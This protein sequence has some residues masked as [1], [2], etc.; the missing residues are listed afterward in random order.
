MFSY[1]HQYAWVRWGNVR[2]EIF[3]INNGT[4]Q[5][6]IASPVFWAVY[7][8]LLIKE[9]RQLGVGAYIAGVF[10]GASAYADDLVL[11]APTRHAMQL[12]LGV[13]EN[14]A[15]CNNIL[16]STD[17]NPSLSK[18]K[19]IFMVGKNINLVKPAPL[20]L[21]GRE[22]PWVETA[23][24]LGHMLHQNG[25]MEYDAKIA[26]AKLIDQSVETRQSFSFASPVEIIRALNIYCSS[27]YGSMLWDL[28]GEAASQY[29]NSW[30]TAVKLSWECPRNTRTYLLQH[31]LSCGGPSAKVDI[32]A[33][34]SRFFRSLCQS[35]SKEVAILA[36]LIGRDKRSVT[37]RNVSQIME[38]T[39]CNVWSDSSVKVKAALLE[40]EMV[41]VAAIDKWRLPY[42]DVLLQQRQEWHYL[43]ESEEKERVQ[44]LIDSLCVN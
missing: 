41:E 14:Y 22:L 29:F 43:G 6:S 18:T 19:C 30:S 15:R 26:R 39:G 42:L 34:Y 37:G 20:T 38:K 11:V 27:H 2:S 36:N 25:T 32:M 13:C 3:P 5:G 31:V 9:L 17:P 8:D 1:Q 24:H 21:N 4:R 35:P 23:N 12:M 28:G 44:G 10:M 33:R 40:A 7:C 16:F